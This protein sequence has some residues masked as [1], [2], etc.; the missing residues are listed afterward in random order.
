MNSSSSKASRRCF[1]ARATHRAVGIVDKEGEGGGG[2]DFVRK[3]QAAGRS[4]KSAGLGGGIKLV[5]WAG[6]LQPGAS[7]IRS[8]CRPLHH[9]AVPTLP[10]HSHLCLHSLLPAR[11]QCPSS[12]LTLRRR[13]P[14][15]PG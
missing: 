10:A 2:E 7:C 6:A 3:H 8:T 12:C 11:P 4:R 15:S 1:Q 13:A 5:L 9:W 14:R